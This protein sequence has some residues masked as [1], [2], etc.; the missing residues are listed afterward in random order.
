MDARN[1]FYFGNAAADQ[2]RDSGWFI[3]Q[4]V[5]TALGARHQ[6]E[7]EVKWGIHPAGESRPHAWANGKATTI[8]VLVR[9]E[10]RA[11]FEVEGKSQVATLKNEGDYV[12]FGPDVVHSWEAIGDTVVLSVR[13][14]SVE[15]WREARPARG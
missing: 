10:L 5:P 9:G 11:T 1:S 12:I 3:G 13:F 2:V 6:T 4:F 7:V 15:L 8:S 14:P